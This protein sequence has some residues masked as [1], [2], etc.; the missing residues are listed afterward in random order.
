MA[1]DNE[2]MAPTDVAEEAEAAAEVVSG[3]AAIVG[4]WNA[5]DS[6]TRSIVRVVV[7]ASGGGITVRVFGACTPTPCDWGTVR[8]LAYAENVSSSAAIAF[9]A[10]Y[11]FNFKEAIV[12]GLVDNGS[13][14]VETYN[15][16]TDNSGRSDYYSRGYF[17]RT[18]AR[19]EDEEEG[20]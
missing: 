14:I 10:Q 4:T 20:A 5:C 19:A 6:A 12:T 8:G 2:F 3:M 17:C 13:L 18:R 11:K 15:H 16:F 1:E 7:A 9:T